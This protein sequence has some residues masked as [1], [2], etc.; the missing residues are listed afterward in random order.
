MP[1]G[2]AHCREWLLTRSQALVPSPQTTPVPREAGPVF[3]ELPSSK[4]LYATAR[5]S[6]CPSRNPPPIPRTQRRCHSAA[7]TP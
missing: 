5:T 7:L 1:F 6:R 3:D 2:S 4:P